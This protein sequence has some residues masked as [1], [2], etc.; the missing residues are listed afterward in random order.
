MKKI[1][2][3]EIIYHVNHHG[4][5]AYDD[6]HQNKRPVVLIVHDWSGQ[7]DFAR[8]KAK[9]L[10]EMGYVGFAVDMYGDKKEGQTKDE[11]LALM[12]P[13]I[14]N[15]ALLA[16]R[17][18]AAVQAVKNIPMVDS[19]KIAVIGFC[20]G[21][22]CALDV[23]RSGEKVAGVISFHA[24][25]WLPEKYQPQKIHAKVLALHGYDDPMA[26]PEQVQQFAD[27]MTQSQADWQIHMYGNTAHA[28]TN[29]LAN[30]PVDGTVYN[31]IADHRSWQSAS[32]FL[33]DIF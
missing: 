12:T 33:A 28:F 18:L 16:E 32:N 31:A 30:D 24:V 14:E 19:T 2:T 1:K 25:F 6:T 13:L 26:K 20:F 8:N 27:E 4:F 10:A 3:S 11:K 5:Y 7:N 17:I 9:Q 23:A 21:G 29:P 22:L 15:R